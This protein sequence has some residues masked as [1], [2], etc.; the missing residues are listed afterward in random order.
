M[1]LNRVLNIEKEAKEVGFIDFDLRHKG[2]Y[3][4]IQ[5]ERPQPNIILYEAVYHFVAYSYRFFIVAKSVAA[6]CTDIHLQENGKWAIKFELLENY[7]K[8]YMKE[9][10][11]P[12]TV[13][14]NSPYNGKQIRL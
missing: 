9:R 10:S 3:I 13:K 14:G 2:E 11:D 8:R 7:I 6:V 12:W 5:S 1:N 4:L